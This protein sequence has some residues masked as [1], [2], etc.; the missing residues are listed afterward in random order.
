MAS[1]L[2]SLPYCLSATQIPSRSHIHLTRE[3]IVSFANAK[4]PNG[5]SKQLPCSQ[6]TR[7]K[8]L[9][10]AAKEK[11]D[12][13]YTQNQNRRSANYQPNLWTH[14]FI[15]I[16]RNHSEVTLNLIKCILESWLVNEINFEMMLIYRYFYYKTNLFN[17]LFLCFSLRTT[18]GLS[19]TFFYV[20]LMQDNW[21]DK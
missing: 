6:R 7:K 13:Q 19:P 8:Q 10:C 21:C 5:S 15:Q 14:E 12:T 9:I 11:D 18:L 20:E 3:R 2:L 1:D 17:F 4:F 16:L